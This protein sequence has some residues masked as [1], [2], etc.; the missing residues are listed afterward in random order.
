MRLMKLGRRGASEQPEPA[1]GAA[2]VRSARLLP[3]PVPPIT[4]TAYTLDRGGRLTRLDDRS[5][6]S[7]RKDGS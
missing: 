3:R 4:R 1:D 6:G 2:G 7:K 5:W